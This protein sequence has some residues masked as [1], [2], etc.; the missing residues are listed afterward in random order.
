MQRDSKE[1]KNKYKMMKTDHR[2]TQM[3]LKETQIDKEK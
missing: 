1:T 2:K 3:D